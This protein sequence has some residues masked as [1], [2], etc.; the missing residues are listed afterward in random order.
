MSQILGDD[1]NRGQLLLGGRGGVSGPPQQAGAMRGGG[2]LKITRDRLRPS[3]QAIVTVP[4][5]PLPIGGGGP[6]GGLGQYSQW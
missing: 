2:V 6:R 5:A 3:L 1:E 4:G